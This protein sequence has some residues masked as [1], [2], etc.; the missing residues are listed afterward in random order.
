MRPSTAIPAGRRDRPEHLDEAGV[1]LAA[2]TSDH[3][4]GIA[5]PVRGI[6]LPVHGGWPEH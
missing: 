2:P 4:H 1:F 6:V 5:L 3:V